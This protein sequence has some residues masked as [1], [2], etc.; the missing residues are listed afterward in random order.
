ML[1]HQDTLSSV[2]VHQSLKKLRAKPGLPGSI[3][4]L[5][6]MTSANR[7]TWVTKTGGLQSLLLSRFNEVSILM[8]A[9]KLCSLQKQQH[10]VHTLSFATAPPF[11]KP[12]EYLGPYKSQLATNYFLF[13]LF[14]NSVEILLCT[15]EGGFLFALRSFPNG[16]SLFW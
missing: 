16:A 3:S 6:C 7:R 5:H 12:V 11:Q 9:E 14:V 10:E 8:F 2:L 13:F 1:A 15:R 4:R